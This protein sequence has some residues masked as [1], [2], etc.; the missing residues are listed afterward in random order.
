MKSMEQSVIASQRT[1]LFAVSIPEAVRLT[2]VG[3]T[4][5]YTEMGSGRLRYRKCGRRTLILI[6]DLRDWLLALPKK[7]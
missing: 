6:E 5:L 3:R 7:G 2:G 4:R 1:E